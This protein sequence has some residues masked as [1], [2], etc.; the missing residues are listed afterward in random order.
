MYPAIAPES[1]S[2]ANWIYRLVSKSVLEL[3][4]KVFELSL[5]L[6]NWE[7][8]W[9]IGR[10]DGIGPLDTLHEILGQAG[11]LGRSFFRRGN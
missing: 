9:A 2:T 11:N 7:N 6:T 4:K 8:P 3:K 10:F 5:D 1:L